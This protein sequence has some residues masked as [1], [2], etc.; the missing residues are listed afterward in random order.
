MKKFIID[1]RTTGLKMAHKIVVGMSGGVDSTVAAILLRQQG[2]EIKGVFM[3]TW[4][5]K[6]FP[7]C[8]MKSA[9][10]GPEEK[11]IEEI[12]KISKILEIPVYFVDARKEFRKK[13]LDYFKKEY[14]LGRTPNPCV[15][16]NRFIKFQFLVDE[17]Q[18]QSIN[19]DFF[20]TGHYAKVEYDKNYKRYILKKGI[21]TAKDQ[22][23]FLFLLTQDQLS[24]IMF[25]LGNYT[26][27]EV[28]KI[29]K[30][31]GLKIAEERE[32]Q[33]FIPGDRFFL[34]DNGIEPGEIV[35]K[36]G[37]ILGR[38]KGII[39]YTIG[40]RKGLGISSKMPLYVIEIQAEKNRIVVGEE[41]ELYRNHLIAEDV[42][43]I[44]IEKIEGPIEAQTKIRYKH[45]PAESKI[46]PL[47]NNRV[48]VVFKKPQR[49][50]TPG[51]A[52][53]FYKGDILIGGG[54]IKG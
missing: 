18:K 34:F 8:K 6:K 9:C 11:E 30:K 2:Y 14:L 38:H 48:R 16:C 53:V 32:S 36:N 21:D 52:A 40:Q 28:K 13:V 33:D 35:D 46:F 50:I 37:N 4:D 5:E 39:Y 51:Q 44:G 26:K 41:K 3:K 20:A 54:F 22:S 27:D 12:K 43:W 47:Q 23:Y 1:D 7:G 17:V 25:P 29:A 10:Y 24:Q 49:A 45:Q 31:H 19:F 15:V 42:N